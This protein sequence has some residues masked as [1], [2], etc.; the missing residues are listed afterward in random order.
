MGSHFV[1]RVFGWGL[2]LLLAIFLFSPVV[3]AQKPD[4]SRAVEVRALARDLAHKGQTAEAVTRLERT[5]RQF[6]RTEEG[7]GCQFDAARLLHLGSDWLGAFEAYQVLMNDFPGSPYNGQAMDSQFRLAEQVVK[8]LKADADGRLPVDLGQ[9]LP[10]KDTTEKMLRLLL[11]NA[12][13]HPRA[14]QARY[15]LGIF[16]QRHGK[17]ADAIAV[18]EEVEEKHA[19]HY[20]A[21]DAAFQ[22]GMIHWKQMESSRDAKAITL[23]RR[24]FQNFLIL[25]PGSDRTAEARHR[26]FLLREKESDELERIAAF[27]EKTGKPQAAEYY[28]RQV[29]KL[30]ESEVIPRDRETLLAELADEEI[31]FEDFVLP[32]DEAAEA[33]KAETEGKPTAPPAALP[34]LD[35]PLPG[36]EALPTDV[37]LPG[38]PAT[39]EGGMEP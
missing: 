11:A 6:R 13:Q 21:D 5:A 8:A 2:W 27:Y 38:Q 29:E 31:A 4:N 37:E 14:P 28:R 32:K 15:L 16:L 12:G 7:A 39:K 24:A 26:L 19:G 36:G 1:S 10:D 17:A 20:L 30:A 9:K 3:Q 18:M 33:K 34:S 35:D 23:A 22:I 25:H